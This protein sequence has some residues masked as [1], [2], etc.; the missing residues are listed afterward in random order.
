MK[1]RH[2]LL[3]V[4]LITLL[5]PWAG[6]QFVGELEQTLRAN[7]QQHLLHYVQLLRT[8][9]AVQQAGLASQTSSP[10]G[11][12][13]G[14]SL[15]ATMILDGYDDDWQSSSA[16]FVPAQSSTQNFPALEYMAGVQGER[17]YLF[18]KIAAE[19]FSYRAR[20]EALSATSDG[21]RLYARN[22]QGLRTDFI[23]SP[24]EPGS[25]SDTG[26]MDAPHQPKLSGIW[27]ETAQGYQVELSLPLA[28][29]AKGIGF[30]LTRG[31][32]WTGV[33][34][35]ATPDPL[36]DLIYRQTTEENPALS[37]TPANTQISWLHEDGWILAQ[38][39]TTATE[40]DSRW[41]EDSAY[42]LAR[43]LLLGI[44][45][46]VLGHQQ[47][48]FTENSPPGQ[49]ANPVI[50]RAWREGMASGWFAHA[51]EGQI[52]LAAAV[53]LPDATGHP[54]LLLAEQ[55]TA[56]IASLSDQ[57]M[58][59]LISVSFLLIAGSLALLLGYAGLLSWRIRRLRDQIQQSMNPQGRLQNRFIASSAGDE[60]GELSQGFAHLLHEI[61]AYTDYLE[62]FARRLSHEMKTPLA[63]VRSS[64]EN[65]SQESQTEA[66][67]IY[68]ERAL[69][70]SQR[71]GQLLHAM[72]EAS[73]L[74]KAIQTSTRETFD[75][76]ALVHELACAYQSLESPVQWHIDIDTGPIFLYG[77]PELIAQ[78]LDKLVDNARDFTPPGKQICLRLHSDGDACEL[79][80]INEGPCLPEGMSQTIFASFI[81]LR[82]PQDTGHLGLGLVIARLICEFHGG[83]ISASNLPDQR[84]VRFCVRLA[85]QR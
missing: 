27:Q 14:F 76:Q 44:F 12:V 28:S 15:P 48:A 70:G 68:I 17:F 16:R 41:Q 3:L 31:K 49:R 20:R 52:I 36:P 63:I 34:P 51:E 9:P 78:L 65:L 8:L 75:L 61:H 33:V 40:S 18:L 19:A 5:I 59:R 57:A 67:R 23:L 4:S 25:L 38:S 84:G 24:V 62:N 58:V 69:D 71:M 83:R 53:T 60:L 81:S 56:E 77:A 2:Q 37:L 79:E 30:S 21:L 26:L 47:P 74:E 80:V 64:L 82:A 29:V 46:W 35:P 10:A 13:Y 85:V 32:Q 55:T 11:V 1:L 22:Q 39:G 72:T 73:R 42:A 50:Q 45:R 6:Y 43:P 7:Q 54:R 66:G